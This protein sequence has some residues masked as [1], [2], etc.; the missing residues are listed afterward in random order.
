[1]NKTKD[2]KEKGRT[3]YEE[4][5]GIVYDIVFASLTRGE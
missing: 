3:F 2:K 1:M 5:I 4:I